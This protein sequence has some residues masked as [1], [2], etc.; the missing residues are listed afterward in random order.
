MGTLFQ[1][2]ARNV[3]RNKSRSGLTI[4][5]IAFGVL[6]SLLLGGF[7][8]GIG[9]NMVDDVVLGKVGA[10][11]VH[12][13]GYDDVKDNQPVHLHMPVHG[14]VVDKIRA[15]PGVTGV[16]P[17]IVL[18]AMIN[19]GTSSTMCVVV[20]ADPSLEPAVLPLAR[21]GLAGQGN[22]AAAPHRGVLGF[23]LA[24]AM[25]VRAGSS[26]VLQAATANGQQNALDLDVGGTT[27]NSVPFESKRMLTVPLAFAQELLQLEGRAT[28]FTVAVADREKVL[29][30]AEQMQ[31]AL[32]PAYHVQ[33]WQQLRPAVV[34]IVTVQRIVLFSI[35]IVFLAIAIIGVMNTMLMSVLERVREIGTMMAV[36]VRRGV[37][38]VLFLFEALTLAALGTATGCVLA[39]SLLGL[40][41]ALGGIPLTP[42][43]SAMVLYVQPIAPVWLLGLTAAAMFV[44]TLGASAYPAF[45]AA[46]LRPVEALRAT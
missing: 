30:I 45:R 22:E 27:N 36:G 25:N 17:R 9:T 18:A 21:R 13:R 15:V 31:A 42:P 5:A 23:E 26:V 11:Q 38:V 3:L 40:A 8:S 7:V 34:D 43:G 14:E 39:F 19:N 12:L 32:G 10:L 33:H 28:E 2:A 1:L 6:M 46:R 16:L 4:G 44:G 37:I 20:G 24:E 41:R 35:C 29:A